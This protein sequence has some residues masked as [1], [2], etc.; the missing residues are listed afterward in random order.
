MEKIG[1]YHNVWAPSVTSFIWTVEPVWLI[2]LICSVKKKAIPMFV[3]VT[4]MLFSYGEINNL[5]E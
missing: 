3:S 4:A 2:L 1:Y 5:L